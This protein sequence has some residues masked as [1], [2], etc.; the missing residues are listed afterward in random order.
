VLKAD[1][2]NQ[3]V[4]FLF[5]HSIAPKTDFPSFMPFRRICEA[6]NTANVTGSRFSSVFQYL[7]CP[8]ERFFERYSSL[9]FSRRQRC[10]PSLPFHSFSGW[11]ISVTHMHI[12][13]CGGYPTVD[14]SIR[15]FL[16]MV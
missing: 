4:R 13:V 2:S 9:G 16:P 5:G 14:S 7:R 10:S 6:R 3:S 15:S 12:S 11:H 1:V 8:P